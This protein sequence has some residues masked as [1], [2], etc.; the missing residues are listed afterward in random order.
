MPMKPSKAQKHWLWKS[1]SLS[2]VPA[3]GT[4]IHLAAQVITR[5]HLDLYSSPSLNP[6]ILCILQNH[7]LS[8]HSLSFWIQCFFFTLGSHHS[9]T[10]AIVSLSLDFLA[11]CQVSPFLTPCAWSPLV[12]LLIFPSNPLPFHSLKYSLCFRYTEPFLVLQ[13]HNFVSY[14]DLHERQHNEVVRALAS[15]ERC[16]YSNLNS[17]FF[18][19]CDLGFGSSLLTQR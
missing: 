19:L 1:S 2:W 3:C 7:H 15:E 6:Q 17:K 10:L 5:I 14:L 16:L 12:C 13:K 8:I 18:F 9:L 11:F 4:N